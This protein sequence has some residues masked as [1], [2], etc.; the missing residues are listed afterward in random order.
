MCSAPDPNAHRR[1]QAKIRHNE[2]LY[3]W[4][5][6]NLAYKNTSAMVKAKQKDVTGLIKSRNLSDLRVGLETQRGKHYKRVE[7]ATKNM[8]KQM[9]TGVGAKGGSMSRQA[10]LRGGTKAAEYLDKIAKS[11]AGL[12]L[13]MGRGQDI[14]LEKQRRVEK[15]QNQELRNK[16]GLPPNFGPGTFYAPVPDNRGLSMLSTALSIG[17]MFATGGMSTAFGVGASLTG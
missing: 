5:S 11:E 15:A 7:V 14:L 4:R 10:M 3:A 8:Y 13:A 2:K 9:A 17:S 16:Q 6:K 1:A 12:E